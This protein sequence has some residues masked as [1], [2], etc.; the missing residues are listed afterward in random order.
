MRATALQPSSQRSVRPR[1]AHAAAR[2]AG[3]PVRLRM[4]SEVDAHHGPAQWARTLMIVPL[5]SSTKKRRTSPR[6]FA[7]RIDNAQ[8]A[9]DSGGTGGVDSLGFAEVDPELRPGIVE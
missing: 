9:L 4:R 2:P 1:R 7:E 5:G 8:S 3:A 6:L